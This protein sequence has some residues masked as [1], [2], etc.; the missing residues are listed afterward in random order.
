[1]EAFMMLVPKVSHGRQDEELPPNKLTRTAKVKDIS[2]LARL[3]IEKKNEAEKSSD[4]RQLTRLIA[5]SQPKYP[6]PPLPDIV[7]ENKRVAGYSVEVAR[8][9]GLRD[10]MEDRHLM[11][12]VMIRGEKT[13]LFAVMD[14]HGGALTANLI[15]S[16]FPQV[17]KEMFG[18]FDWK[19]ANDI[20]MMSFW[21][22]VS[23]ELEGYIETELKKHPKDYSG[24]TL[25]CGIILGDTLWVLNVGDSRTVLSIDGKDWQMSEDDTFNNPR[26]LA[27]IEA[28]NGKII[29]NRLWGELAVACA[30]GDIQYRGLKPVKS[31][32]QYHTGMT[33]EFG[34]MKFKL[35]QEKGLKLV[36]ASDGFWDWVGTREA[37]L[38]V[39]EGKSAEKLVTKSLKR[40]TEDNT[41]V[42][43]V[44]LSNKT[45]D[46]PT[47]PL[48]NPPA[49]PPQGSLESTQPVDDANM[50]EPR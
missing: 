14:G 40:K 43:V 41:T 32:L 5:P 42:M 45:E 30:F 8:T 21:K 18:G 28:N 44:D 38:L 12:E 1:M 36:L 37:A 46:P 20:Q 17:L 6:V 35:G 19:K 25:T 47:L 31:D 39:K 33:S 4:T 15:G 49:D 16:Y 48:D 34:I 7:V 29:K 27:K 24:S 11:Q 23:E 26:S 3:E 10:Y 13:A 2:Q 9:Q 50:D 22:Q